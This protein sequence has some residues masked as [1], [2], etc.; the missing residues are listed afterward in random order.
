MGSESVEFTFAAI[1]E[2]RQIAR[3]IVESRI[4][5]IRDRILQVKES[6]LISLVP[7]G[8]YPI[9]WFSRQE[10]EFRIPCEQK[11]L[12]EDVY[13]NG[14]KVGEFVGGISSPYRFVRMNLHSGA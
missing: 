10:C 9:E 8:E 13:I 2:Q 12:E 14:N 6:A 5:D 4:N 7:D 3:S 1:S 11:E